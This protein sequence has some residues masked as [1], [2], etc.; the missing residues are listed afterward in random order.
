MVLKAEPVQA[1]KADLGIGLAE[2]H[3]LTK[4]HISTAPDAH[5]GWNLSS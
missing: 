1:Q 2:A 3:R 4:R 5:G